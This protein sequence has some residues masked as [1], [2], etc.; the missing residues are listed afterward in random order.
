MDDH[1]R[2]KIAE[3]GMA[4]HWSEERDRLREIR[5]AREAVIL[6]GLVTGQAAGHWPA[7][8]DEEEAIDAYLTLVKFPIAKW[9]S[10][11]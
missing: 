10:D 1:P 7:D 11:S 5:R 4:R 6:E 9:W 2:L 3:V 8:D